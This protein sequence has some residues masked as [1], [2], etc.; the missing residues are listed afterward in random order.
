MLRY[1]SRLQE[2]KYI[3]VIHI[4]VCTYINTVC[5]CVC[6]CVIYQNLTNTYLQVVE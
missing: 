2:S 6:V 5:V 3:F 4:Y 1:K